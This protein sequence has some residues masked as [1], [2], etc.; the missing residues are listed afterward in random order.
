M[1]YVMM[2]CVTNIAYC[3]MVGYLLNEK[4]D[5][6]WKVVF[7]QKLSQFLLK[8]HKFSCVLSVWADTDLILVLLTQQEHLLK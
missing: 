5:R 1:V 4:L 8:Q 2:L 7:I 6:V 3:E